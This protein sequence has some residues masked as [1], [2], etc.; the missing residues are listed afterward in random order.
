MV[1]IV[2][3]LSVSSIQRKDLGPQGHDCIDD[4]MVVGVNG[5]VSGWAPVR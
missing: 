2:L 3:F 4:G 1:Y 5:M